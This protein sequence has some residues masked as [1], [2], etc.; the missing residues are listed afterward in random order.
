MALN[1]DT[2][3][4]SNEYNSTRRRVVNTYRTFRYCVDT[5]T[6]DSS[7]GAVAVAVAGGVVVDR[8]VANDRGVDR[9]HRRGHS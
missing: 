6:A 2:R 1:L 3:Y 7:H 4:F 8:A 9:G 5:A